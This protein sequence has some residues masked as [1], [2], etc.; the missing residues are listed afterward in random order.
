MGITR[1]TYHD[2][3]KRAADDTAVVEAMSAICD[4]FEAYGCGAFVQRCA[5]KAWS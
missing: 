3:P 4:E 1:S 5:S 2:Q